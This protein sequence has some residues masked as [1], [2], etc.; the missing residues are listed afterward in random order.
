VVDLEKCTV[1]QGDVTSVVELTEVVRRHGVSR[2]VHT[3]ANPGLTPGAE[4]YPFRAVEI[5]VVGT[6]NVLE[7]ARIFDVARVVLCSTTSL[8]FSMAGG[9]DGGAEGFEEA[10]A[11]P[12][13]VYA[14]T[15][16]AAENLALNYVKIFGL[17]VMVVRLAGVFGPWPGGGGMGTAMLRGL[18]EDALDGKP[19]VV[20]RMEIDWVYS[21]DVANGISRAC[22]VESPP[23]R[24][25]NLSNG[26]LTTADD[27]VDIIRRLV[28]GADVRAGVPMPGVAFR[29]ASPS[30]L[31]RAKAYLGFEPEH[32]MLSGMRE[33]LASIVEHRRRAATK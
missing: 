28:P 32:D 23:G 21:T 30:N 3:A 31:D 1:V 11:R 25:V 9:E 24:V 16:Q 4:R 20:P 2:I 13:T 6:A 29:E 10:T 14:T 7:V 22:W 27:L 17:D 18:L 19:V 15:K 26:T 33:F 8:Y 12:D 5:N